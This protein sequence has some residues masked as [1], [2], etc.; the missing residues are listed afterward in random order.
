MIKRLVAS[1]ALAA[2]L[3]AGSASAAFKLADRV[4]ETSTT[5]G[6]GPFALLGALTTSYQTF[7]SQMANADTTWCFVVNR[8]AAEWESGLCTYNTGNTLTVT[9]VLQSSNANAAV[10]FSAGTKDVYISNSGIS[11]WPVIYGGTGSAPAGDDQL[12]VSLSATAASWKTV[13]DCTDTGGNHL[14]YTQSTNAFSCGTSGGGG[15][16]ITTVGNVT[17]GTA[18]FD[19][20]A[21]TQLTG[22]ASSTFTVT[23]AQGVSAST[24]GN[25]LIRSGAGGSTSGNSGSISLTTGS[26]TSGATGSINLTTASATGTAQNGGDINL[27]TGAGSLTSNGTP[28]NINITGGTAPNT[29]DAGGGAINVIAGSGAASTSGLG[30]GG[31]LTLSGGRGAVSG[32]GGQVVITSGAGG[33]TTGNSGSVSL[34]SGTSTNGTTGAASLGS[35]NAVGTNRASGSIVISVGTS[36]GSATSGPINITGGSGVTGTGSAANITSGA[37]GSTSGASGAVTI[38]SGTTT[39][40]ATGAVT[41]KSANSTGT[42]RASG[43]LSLTTGNSKG[44]AVPGTINITAGNTDNAS[45][46]N[47]GAISIAAGT[48]ANS[49]GAGTANGGAITISGGQVTSVTGTSSTSGAATISSGIVNANTGDASSG[50]VTLSAPLP[51]GSGIAGDIL[52]QTGTSDNGTHLRVSG[53]TNHTTFTQTTAPTVTANCGSSPSFASGDTDHT[54]TLNVGTG[55]TATTCTVTFNKTWTNIPKCI[56]NDQSAILAIQAVPTTSTVVLT[57]T[58]PFAASTKLDVICMGNQ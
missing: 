31:T 3:I 1:L 6:A 58:A 48:A 50:N 19:G 30:A 9:T 32:N 23:I 47:G 25:V 10:T 20:T 21:G 26:T 4:W 46:T 53:V 41:I 28:G 14:N 5:T 34:K 39:D 18:A 11:V 35:G 38:A 7:S 36:T 52:F 13:P 22:V 33:P 16:G 27:L 37:G 42:N 40:G 56:V 8:N 24:G 44:T 51:T 2:L 17:S 45:A 55:G 49:N 43:A 54:F 12:L 15:G 29:S 57:A